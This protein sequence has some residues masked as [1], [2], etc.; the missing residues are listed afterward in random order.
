MTTNRRFRAAVAGA[1]SAAALAL[2][3]ASPAGA[4]PIA[5][6]GTPSLPEFSGSAATPHKL[7]DPRAR[8]RTRTWPTTRTRTSTTTR[9]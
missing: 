1:L 2:V 5:D 8:P 7:D 4:E 6:A 3:L 9:G